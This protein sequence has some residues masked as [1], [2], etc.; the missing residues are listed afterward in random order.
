MSFD[1][2]QRKAHAKSL[3]VIAR[4]PDKFGIEGK[5]ISVSI[6]EELYDFEKGKR[7][8]LAVPDITLKMS[9]G[10]VVVIEYK[11][12][13]N[14]FEK[15]KKQIERVGY[16]YGKYTNIPASKLQTRII[17]GADYPFLKKIKYF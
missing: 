14:G 9:S 15:A 11:S 1:S 6:E 3:E 16:W 4:N 7:I 13:G 12:N 10:E 2:R 5:V 17:S 8:L